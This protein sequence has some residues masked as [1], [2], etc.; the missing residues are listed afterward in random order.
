MLV[1]IGA[2]DDIHHAASWRRSCPRQ[3]EGAT[4]LARHAVHV[5]GFVSDY[6]SGESDF[7]NWIT[8]PVVEWGG[9]GL[10][11]DRAMAECPEEGCSLQPNSTLSASAAE[12]VGSLCLGHWDL[13][14]WC[15]FPRCCVDR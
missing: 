14:Q 13:G 7:I 12:R 5:F 4:I 9:G 15:L 10:A 8:K 11:T 2:R 1:K 6:V 3:Y